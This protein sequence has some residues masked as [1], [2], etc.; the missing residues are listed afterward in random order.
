LDA[1]EGW[2]EDNTAGDNPWDLQAGHGTHIAG[3]LYARE[4]MEGNNTTTSCRVKFCCVS[5]C[6]HWFLEF[7]LA[8]RP[9][10]N[11]IQGGMKFKRSSAEDEM[12]EVQ[13]V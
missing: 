1:E 12:D 10:T 5:Q 7:E 3:M 11:P 13:A 4:L 6:W 2:D 8:C 9:S